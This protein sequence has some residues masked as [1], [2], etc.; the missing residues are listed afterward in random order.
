MDKIKV[1]GGDSSPVYQYLK[2]AS[3]DTGLITWN[4]AKVKSFQKKPQKTKPQGIN[5]HFAQLLLYLVGAVFGKK[6]WYCAQ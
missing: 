1:N 5:V 6:G 3:G 4:F 2:V